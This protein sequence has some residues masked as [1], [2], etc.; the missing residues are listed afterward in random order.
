MRDIAESVGEVFMVDMAHVAGLV[1]AGLYPFPVP[2]ALVFSSRR[3]HTSCDRDWSSDVC[4]SD[5]DESVLGSRNQKPFNRYF[6]EIFEP[7]RESLPD[8]CV[9]DGELIVEIDG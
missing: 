4:S 8:W 2:H 3:R 6:P 9:V 1:A 5:L 7:L